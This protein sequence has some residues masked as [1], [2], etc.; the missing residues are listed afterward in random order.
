[1]TDEILDDLERTIMS[2]DKEGALGLTKKAIERGMDP[3]KVLDAMTKAIREVG[4]GF[5]KGELWLPELVAAGEVMSDAM[6]IIEK[7]IE[8]KG[9]KRTTLGNVVIGTVFGDIHN[10]GKNMVVALLRAEGF[11]VYDLGVNVSAD[12]FVEAAEKNKADLIAMSALLTTT[13]P[14]QKKVIS[15]LRKQSS[16]YKVKVMVGGAAVTREFCDSVGA[17][18]YAPTAPTAAKLARVLLGK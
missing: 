5:E 11:V 6:P 2:C 16:E 15:T 7:E 13:A 1:M 10:I 3:V 4:L 14:E 12:A 17:D 8:R 9:V 18:G